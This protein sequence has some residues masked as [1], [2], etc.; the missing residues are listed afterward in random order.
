MRAG[1]ALAA[2][3]LLAAPVAAQDTP[4]SGDGF[5]PDDDLDCVIYIGSLLADGDEQGD[6]DRRVALSSSITYFAGHF[7][8]QNDED[9]GEALARRY[10][11][12]LERSPDEVAQVCAVRTRAF[13]MRLQKASRALSGLDAGE[14]SA[15][16]TAVAAPSE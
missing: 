1:F 12:F 6:A 4:A 5:T 9:L 3:A 2:A 16:E 7:E 8:A 13:G 11:G 10:S 14:P 15:E